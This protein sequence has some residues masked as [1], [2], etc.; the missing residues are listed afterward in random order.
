[1]RY[2]FL[3]AVV[4][5]GLAAPAAGE[6]RVETAVDVG[7]LRAVPLERPD[8]AFPGGT[9]TGQE[10]WVR[11][12]FVVTPDGRVTDP[13]VVDSLGGAP[14]E[15][16]ALETLA[17]WRF[18][19]A[20]DGGEIANNVV[21]M[22]FELVRGR[23]AATSNFLR[24]SSRIMADISSE[25]TAQARTQLDETTALGGWNLYESTMLALMNG[26]LEDQE[27]SAF[28]KLEHYRRALAADT[29]GAVQGKD[30][31]E[32]LVR[33]F[34]VEYGAGQYGAALATAE[35][36]AA[37]SGGTAELDAL[38]G[39]LAEMRAAL[40]HGETLVAQARLAS[41]CECTGAEGLWQYPPTRKRFAFA[42]ADPGVRRFEAR[43]DAWRLKG[44]VDPAA[45]YVIPEEARNC[46][47]FVFGAD[48]AGFEFVESAARMDVSAG[49]G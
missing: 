23:D 1:M 29:G 11:V 34:E 44:K 14:F 16:A 3:A 9:R 31:L 2:R 17:R 45:T 35:A 8:P 36:L 24:R 48:G 49:R 37:E 6:P 25:R 22:R 21:D 5:A 13:I 39:P 7:E 33:I 4:V 46:R 19:P 28:G 38:A 20:P 18:E 30:R 26:R 10:G 27:G 42:K 32:L 40:A 12:N 15:Q 43:C 41:A 47:V